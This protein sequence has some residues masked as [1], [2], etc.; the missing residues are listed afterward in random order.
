LAISIGL[1]L[2]Q[3]FALD[4]IRVLAESS[5]AT[6]VVRTELEATRSELD[7]A[8]SDLESSK[9]KAKEL[10]DVLSQTRRLFDEANVLVTESRSIVDRAVV[11]TADLRAWGVAMKAYVES[12]ESKLKELE[13][14]IR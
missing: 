6:S 2:S 5:N 1:G 3:K 7:R 12:L 11:T 14:S 13:E 10:E 8:I 4:K 9:E